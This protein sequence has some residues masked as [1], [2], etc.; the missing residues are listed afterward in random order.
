MSPK[1]P[2]TPHLPYSPGGSK[3]DRRLSSV[4]TLLR[5]PLVITEKM[6]GSNVCLERDGCFARSHASAPKHPSFDAFKAYHASVKGLIGGDIQIFGE[7]LY[8]RHSI[9]YTNLP[10]YFLVFGVRDVAS[11]S[12]AEWEEVEAWADCLRTF[13]VPRLEVGRF[14]SAS[15]LQEAIEEH[16]R[17]KGLHREREGVVVRW[18]ESFD[19]ECFGDAVAKWVREDHVQTSDHWS[20]Q[21]LVRNGLLLGG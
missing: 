13:T 10:S 17:A 8:A 2:R 4:D 5:I 14:E 6:D 18:E 16:A 19:T 7:W 1:Y 15:D 20:H 3:D 12:W 21:A 11:G 9:A